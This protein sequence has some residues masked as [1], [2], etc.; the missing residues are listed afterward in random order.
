MLQLLTLHLG[1]CFQKG[2]RG[3]RGILG[4]LLSISGNPRGYPD[5]TQGFSRFKGQNVLRGFKAASRDLRGLQGN[6]KGPQEHIRKF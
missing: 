3:L 6:F 4:G 2:S 1:Y 5:V